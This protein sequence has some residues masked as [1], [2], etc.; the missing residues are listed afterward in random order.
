MVIKSIAC[1][2]KHTVFVSESGHV[3]SMGGNN[4]GQLGIGGD[5]PEKN[6]PTLVESLSEVVIAKIAC[7]NSHTLAISEKGEAYAWG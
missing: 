7:G 1:G 6:T 2:F 4:F 5:I 3:Y